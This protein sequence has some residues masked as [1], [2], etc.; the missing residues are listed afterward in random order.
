VATSDQIF[1]IEGFDQLNRKLKQ[2]P[3]RVKRLEVLK[4]FRRLSKPIQE[5]YRRNLPKGQEPHTRYTRGGGKTTY[6]PGNLSESVTAQTVG[7]KY[8][9][10]NPSIAVRPSKRG[11]SEGYY[12]FMVVPKGFTGKGRGSRKGA[13]DVVPQAR[14]ATLQQTGGKAN[15]EAREKTAAYIQKQIDRLSR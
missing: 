14:D 6:E 1:E 12:R 9:D 2:L 3:D 4:I 8:S 11:R 10:G 5:A 15:R 7:V 13:N